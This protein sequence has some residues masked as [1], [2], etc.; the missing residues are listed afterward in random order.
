[1]LQPARLGERAKQE[2]SFSALLVPEPAGPLEAKVDHTADGA[3]DGTRAQG[4]SQL[5]QSG[6][7]HSFL[8]SSVPQE[9]P[10]FGGHL[11]AG[12][13]RR[14]SLQFGHHLLGFSTQQPLALGLQPLLLLLVVEAPSQIRGLAEVFHGMVE[15]APSAT[16]STLSAAVMCSCSR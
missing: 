14:Q 2:H 7:L 5:R 12:V 8:F 13:L 4:Q 9:I 1:M 15:L 10:Q 16:T 3:L 11:L 6:I